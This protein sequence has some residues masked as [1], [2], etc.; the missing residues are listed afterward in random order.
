MIIGQ[1]VVGGHT[2]HN[3]AATPCNILFSCCDAFATFS[4]WLPP[5]PKKNKTS[6]NIQNFLCLD[7]FVSYFCILGPR[8]TPFTEFWSKAHP[9]Q[10]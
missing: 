10:E 1:G 5:P 6:F 9:F 3:S 8:P 4:A 2:H 7:A